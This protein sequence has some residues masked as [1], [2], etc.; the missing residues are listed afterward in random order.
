MSSPPRA[1]IDSSSIEKGSLSASEKAGS[2]SDEKNIPL[3]DFGGESSLPPPPE[4]TPEQEKTLYRK[5]DYK[6]MPILSL[7]YLGSFL[8]RG[9]IGNA[10]LAGLV[11]QLNLVE[12][13]YNIAL[14][15]FFIPYCLAECPAKYV[16]LFFD[17]LDGYPE[18]RYIRDYL[19]VSVNIYMYISMLTYAKIAWG[20]S[21]GFVKSYAFLRDLFNENGA[22]AD[23]AVRNSH[24]YPQLV[25]VRICLGVA[26]AGFF[27]GV[28][29][30]LTMWYPRHKLQYRIGLFFGAATIAGA[31]SGLLA[32]AIEFMGGARGL[33]AWSWIFFLTLLRCVD[34]MKILEGV[35]TAVVGIISL[36]KYDNS[37]VGEAEG[38]AM[39]YVWAALRDWQVW[40]HVLIYM[41]IITPRELTYSPSASNWR[42]ET[43]N[44][45][46]DYKSLEYHSS[47]LQ[48]SPGM[49]NEDTSSDRHTDPWKS[50]GFSTPITQ[51]LTVPPYVFA[52]LVLLL[53]GHYSDKTKLRSPFILLGLAMCL[54]GFSINISDAPVG[55]KYFGTFFCVA[56]SYAA[57]PGVVTW[58][59]NNL[60]GQYKRGVGMAVHIGIGNFGG[61][62]A[63]NIFR[64][65]DAPRYILGHG[66]ELLFVGI[67][68]IAVPLAMFLY[69]RV[70]VQREEEL[71]RIGST[72]S[73]Y[74]VEEI[75][76]MGDR[77][78][79]FRY[80]L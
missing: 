48:S 70:N 4:L 72:T 34:L 37:T 57:F 50:F 31:F 79:D 26:E 20:M 66:L 73:K 3:V 49:W 2:R 67:G 47:Y 17:L 25:G 68:F 11:T 71:H 33:E 60:A 56:G 55:V 8:D 43:E 39:R 62:I 40:L 44:F 32:F 18:L 21:M 36:F 52:T 80:T 51:L 38:F 14:T 19:F 24:R 23:S 76:E 46:F 29:Y 54:I 58:M 59:G 45:K 69:V 41:S 12:N 64:T 15:M 7:M 22:Y 35:A 6:L 1:D 75:H 65:Q 30:Y 78:P 61:A 13:Q 63:S 28:V 74:S 42:T 53:F 77:A 27:P 10:K 16:I 5:I 9:N